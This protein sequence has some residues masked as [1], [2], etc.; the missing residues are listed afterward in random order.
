MPSFDDGYVHARHLLERSQ[1]RIERPRR[2][3]SKR[4]TGCDALRLRYWAVRRTGRAMSCARATLNVLLP[5]A[6]YATS[7][8]TAAHRYATGQ[9]FWPSCFLFLRGFLILILIRDAP[10][11]AMFNGALSSS[12]R[13]SQ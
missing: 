4:R 1:H 12:G 2:S 7:V 10:P 3:Y 5:T 9:L 13:R 8:P 6:E 11:V